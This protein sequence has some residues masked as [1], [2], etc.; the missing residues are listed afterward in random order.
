MMRVVEIND[1]LVS[2]LDTSDKSVD[3]VTRDEAIHCVRDLNIPIFGVVSHKG[4]THTI[5]TAHELYEKARTKLHLHR[6]FELCCSADDTLIYCR[7]DDT[8]TQNFSILLEDYMSGC[9]N[10]SFKAFCQSANPDAKIT[11]IFT[12]NLEF[13]S[14]VLEDLQVTNVIYDFMQLNDYNASQL[15]KILLRQGTVFDTEQLINSLCIR[16]MKVRFYYYKLLYY[17]YKLRGSQDD[18]FDALLSH[19]DLADYKKIWIN[20]IIEEHRGAWDSI[21]GAALN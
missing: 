15:Y 1:N 12:N 20:R 9:M 21:I 13:D 10:N 2:V 3:T 11:F 17:G 18:K 4:T 8:L 7:C 6:D 5:H 14:N 19:K 16:D